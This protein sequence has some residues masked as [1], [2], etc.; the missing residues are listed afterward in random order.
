[1]TITTIMTIYF[2][3]YPCFDL[4]DSILL[5]YGIQHTIMF[6]FNVKVFTIYFFGNHHSVNSLNFIS[7]S[8]YDY[9]FITCYDF[10]FLIIFKVN[11]TS[12]H[13][14]NTII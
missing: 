12:N 1:M 8:F 13:R 7:V 11:L 3:I 4:A 2:E 14:N 9:A 5:E 6:S 10:N